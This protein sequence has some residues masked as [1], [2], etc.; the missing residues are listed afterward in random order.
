MQVRLSVVRG[1]EAPQLLAWEAASVQAARD[2]AEQSGYVVVHAEAVNWWDRLRSAGLSSSRS[3]RPTSASGELLVWVEQLHAL[4]MAGLSVIEAL[5]TLLRQPASTWSTTMQALHDQLK[6]GQALSH[7]MASQAAF[8]PLLVALVRSAEQTSSLPEALARYLD[9]EQRSAHVRHQVSSVALYPALLL[10]VGGAVLMF[11]GFFVMPRFARIFQGMHGDLPWTA[12]MMVAWANLLKTHG[13]WVWGVLLGLVAGG[14][15]LVGTAQGRQLMFQTL[16]RQQWLAQRLETYHLAR[17][18][19]TT[20]MLVKGGIPLP[21][22]VDLAAHVLPVA[23]QARAR[24]VLMAMR[25]G[26]SPAQAFSIGAMSTPVADRLVQAGER[27]GDV[28]L[29]LEKTAHFHE[30]ELTRWLERS[31]RVL[32]PLV[33]V[34]I[35]LGVGGVVIM[36]Y[37]PIFELAS[38]V[39]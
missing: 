28:G 34:L 25:D 30:V 33:M 39:Q 15:M 23:M 13:L 27:S 22:S 18:Y 16:T 29:M 6:Q 10:G 7:A 32:E 11:L 26:L 8:P 36:M 21:E 4:L 38:A 35:G 19:R 3:R 5:D 9:H 20:S 37:L 12:Q 24:G 17:W 14:V 31:M 1:R 2:R